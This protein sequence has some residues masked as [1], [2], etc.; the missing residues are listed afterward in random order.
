[1]AVRSYRRKRL[2]ESGAKVRNVIFLVYMEDLEAVGAT[3]YNLCNYLDGLHC[4]AVVSPIHDRD[5]FT[6]HDVF[7]W[8]TRHLDDETGD[9][10]ERYI[11]DAPYVGKPKKPHVHVGIVSKS[12]L[13][14]EGWSEFMSGLLYIRPSMFEKMEDYSGF[15]RYCAHLDSP[16]KAKYNAFDVVSIAG[17]DLS[18]LTKTT[19]ADK[20]RNLVELRN[21]CREHNIKSYD[22]LFDFVI[23]TGD[24][25]LISCFRGNSA[26]M[27]AYF[28]SAKFTASLA[29]DI[30]SEIMQELDKDS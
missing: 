11:D 28:R 19:E 3:Y 17:A 29:S 16:E 23:D 24:S 20:V 21:L 27:N 14:A 26:Q 4:K 18:D 7:E 2:F 1:M 15:V 10:M 5:R 8:C 13:T 30:R 25:D 6:S 22:K 9:L 12:Q